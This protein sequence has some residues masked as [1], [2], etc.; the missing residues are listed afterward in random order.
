M[1][2]REDERLS[3]EALN[4]YLQDCLGYTASWSPVI[5][6]P[7]DV[8]FSVVLP[9]KSPERWAVEITGLFQY[10]EWE[11][12]EVNR[13]AFQ[14]R[15]H[16]MVERFNSEHEHEMTLTY[17]LWIDGPLPVKLLN[18]LPNRILEYVRSGQ[19]AEVA[20]DHAEAVETVCR[21]MNSDPRDPFVQAALQ[22]VVQQYEKI[23]VNA[24]PGKPGIYLASMLPAVAFI[25]RDEK[26]ISQP[27]KMIGDIQESVTY[28]VNRI[29]KAKLP[30]LA[31]VAQ[32]SN[33][34]RRILLVWSDFVLAHASEVAKAIAL[35]NL[36][37]ADLDA[38]FFVDFGWKGVR[39]VADLANIARGF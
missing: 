8:D 16:K 5:N 3:A 1:P 24:K 32:I 36:S 30:K 39:L 27:P 34:D 18:D 19:T 6:D 10:A 31:K 7:P 38:I 33:Y 20:L 13:L 17:G 14:P 23:R 22:Q 9:G 15:L 12:A 35:Q 11:G 29:L 26:A 2:L 21:Q 4:S 25:P 28:S 37:A